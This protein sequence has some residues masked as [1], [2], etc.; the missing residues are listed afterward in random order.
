MQ[1]IKKINPKSVA[2]VYAFF[3]AISAFLM[4]LSVSFANIAERLLQGASG[5]GTVLFVVLF[6][7]LYGA[8]VG[9]ICALVGVVIGYIFG[10]IFASLYNTAV[11][12]KI[13]SGIKI[14]LE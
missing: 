6:N 12:M 13:I 3:L 5:F 11:K 7:I 2:N 10:Y 1:T 4:G 8:F 14:D 9:L